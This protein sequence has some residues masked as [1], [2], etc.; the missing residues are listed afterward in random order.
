MKRSE[1]YLYCSTDI[2]SNDGIAGMAAGHHVKCWNEGTATEWN[3]PNTGS[4]APGA[5]WRVK[6]KGLSHLF[7]L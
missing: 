5:R 2:K 6:K 1:L 4:L 3:G 7:M